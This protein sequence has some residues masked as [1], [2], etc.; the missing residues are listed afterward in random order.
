MTTN[1]YSAVVD[2]TSDAGFRAWGSLLSARL[3]AAGLVQTAD[4]GQINW[5]TVTRP[6][7]NTAG[8]YEIWRLSNSSLYF[9]IEYGTGSSATTPQMWITV[10]Q[11]SNGSGTLT[12]Q[13]STR[14][15]WT[16][17]AAPTSTLTSYNTYICVLADALSI[18]WSLNGFQA[19][20]SAGG[21]LI[22]GR[23]VDS[24]GATTSIGF[25][26][27]RQINS[28]Q[29][30]ACQCARIASTASTQAESTYFSMAV[31]APASTLT[32]AGA[33]QAYL[34]MMNVPDVFPFEWACTYKNS[35]VTKANTM[36]FAPVGP[37]SRT[38]L[39]LGGAAA[40]NNDSSYGIAMIYE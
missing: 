36:S 30:M 22:V 23:T 6:A 39:A 27:L 20:S 17:N 16:A 13:L 24:T 18:C 32:N 35:E 8:G 34:V 7:T 33:N 1:S 4:T 28:S 37:T 26:V 31:G 21:V 10:G 15:T 5:T 2:H 12:G 25:A 3:A 11:G 38:F 19:A 29:A 14:N 40:N 9:K